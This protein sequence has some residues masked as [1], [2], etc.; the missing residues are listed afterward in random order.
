M[1]FVTYWVCRLKGCTYWVYRIMWVSL[2]SFE[3]LQY[4]VCLIMEFCRGIKKITL[5]LQEKS[6]LSAMLGILRFKSVPFGPSDF[7]VKKLTPSFSKINF[8]LPPD[9]INAKQS[10]RSPGQ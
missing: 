8:N 1:G 2:N 10:Q 3:L 6:F 7:S 5:P 9:L 4:E